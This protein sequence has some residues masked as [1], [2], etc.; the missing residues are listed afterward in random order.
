MAYYVRTIIV[1]YYFLSAILRC[2][3]RTCM[4]RAITN[5]RQLWQA[6]KDAQKSFWT[7]EEIDFSGDLFDWT[8]VLTDAERHLLSVILAFFASSD[9]IV[10]ENLVQQFCAEVQA[11]EAQCFYGFQIM[12]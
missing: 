8:T 2:V 10:A 11:P 3:I 6:Y 7:T 1:L 5:K 12:M 4:Q 9:G